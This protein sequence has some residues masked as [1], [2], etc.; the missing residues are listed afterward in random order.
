MTHQTPRTL[1]LA[2]AAMITL[3]FAATSFAIE[4]PKMDKKKA[5]ATRIHNQSMQQ[6]KIVKPDL[7]AKIT[8][9][10]PRADGRIVIQG[11]IKNIGDGDFVCARNQAAGQV[12]LHLPALS[13]PS[14]WPILTERK[15][16]RLNKGQSMNIQGIYTIADFIRWSG[17][18]PSAGEC[19]VELDMSFI[20]QVSLDPD[21]LSDGNRQNDDADYGNNVDKKH[22]SAIH[23]VDSYITECP[24]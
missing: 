8:R 21:I 18:N 19:P 20:V 10:S 12:Q 6:V 22:C 23:G 17:G 16:T 13:G 24:Y 2:I 1:T 7:E 15:F 14:A 9:V 3:I 4:A 5:P 11:R